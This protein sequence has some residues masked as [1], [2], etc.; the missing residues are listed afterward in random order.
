VS[1]TAERQWRS[2]LNIRKLRCKVCHETHD[3]LTWQCQP[4]SFREEEADSVVATTDG[5]VVAEV[6]GARRLRW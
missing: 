2:I 3:Y 4:V 1:T 5:E 6:V